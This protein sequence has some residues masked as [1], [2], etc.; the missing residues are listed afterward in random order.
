M[1]GLSEIIENSNLGEAMLIGSRA[2]AHWDKSFIINER[3]WDIISDVRPNAMVDIQPTSKFIGSEFLKFA[4]D[5]FVII[6]GIEYPI[7]SLRGLSALK[8]SHLSLDYRW[9]KHISFWHKFLKEHFNPEDL[10]LVKERERL[11]LLDYKQKN[12]KLN[13]SNVDFF[14]DFVQKKYDHDYIHELVAF[15]DEPLYC[16]LKFDDKRHLAWC[17]IE[18]WNQLS[19]EDKLKC[20][21][22]EASTIALE[23]F[24]LPQKQRFPN[25]AYYDALQKVCT[26]LTSGWFRDYA[27][28]HWPELMKM[29]RTQLLLDITNKLKY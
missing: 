20:I 23:R 26:S 24:L 5:E 14:D 17:E 1:H 28:W 13:M 11:T 27:I 15:Y 2:Y 16:K 9:I 22:E 29:S 19:H 4:S 10:P 6:G 8:L 12:P 21:C 3:D 18:L 25:V 7:C